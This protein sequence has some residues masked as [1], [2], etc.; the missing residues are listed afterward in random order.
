MFLTNSR[1]GTINPA[2]M[3]R[4]PVSILM[5]KLSL[6]DRRAIWKNFL[7]DERLGLTKER[8]N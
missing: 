1:I 6:D 3:S 7:Q 2:F 4:I 8:Q 5:D